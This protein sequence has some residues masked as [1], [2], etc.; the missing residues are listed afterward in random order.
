MTINI[1]YVHMATSDAMDEYVTGKLEKLAK[2]FDGA[3]PPKEYISHF[4]K[5]INITEDFF[6]KIANK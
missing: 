4:C 3:K 6:W 2:K 5:Q 1:Q